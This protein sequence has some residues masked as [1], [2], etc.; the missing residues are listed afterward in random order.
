VPGGVLGVGQEGGRADLS[1]SL[2]WVDW[3]EHCEESEMVWGG[4]EIVKP[5]F[6]KLQAR[7]GGKEGGLRDR[8]NV[9]MYVGGGGR[10][11]KWL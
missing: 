7:Q 1:A 6:L 4:T 2:D 3:G 9:L 10:G 5:S 11:W 8:G